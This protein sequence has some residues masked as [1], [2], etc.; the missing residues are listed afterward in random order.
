MKYPHLFME[1]WSTEEIEEEI[2][3]DHSKILMNS[4]KKKLSGDILEF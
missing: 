2:E 4:V 1:K 3:K